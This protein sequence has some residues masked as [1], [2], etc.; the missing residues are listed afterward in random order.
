MKIPFVDFRAQY[1]SIKNAVDKATCRVLGSGSFILGEDV[2]LFE[3]EFARY[4]G[5]RYAVGVNSG[6]DALFLGL[7]SLGIGQGDEV[8][9]PAFTYIATALAV[10]F[11]GAV[12]VFVDIDPRSYNIDVTKIERAI[13]KKTKAILC[14][15]LY[16]QPCNMRIIMQLARRHRLKLVEDCAQAAGVQYRGKKVG[17]FGDVG[18][19][20]FYP[21]KNLGACGDGGIVITSKKQTYRMLL[22]LRDYGRKNR[23]EHWIKGYNSRLDTIQ[24]AILRIKLKKLD[25]WNALRRKKAKAYNQFLSRVDGVLPPRALNEAEHVYHV[26]AVRVRNRDRIYNSLR[27]KGVNVLIHY[28]KP[29]HLQRAY[30]EL[31][32]KCSDFPVA[33]RVAEEILSL[34]LYPELSVK[35]IKRVVSQLKSCLSK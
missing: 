23:Y 13:S 6:T 24:A 22:M 8:I 5:A 12:P 18:C 21:T 1:K 15:H 34:P 33:E 10:S 9:I 16:G 7:R 26:Y 4:C 19:F 29:L 20:S 31:G 2:G 28:P 32:H 11:T 35:D 25:K 17:T 27:K 30:A 3:K 14:V